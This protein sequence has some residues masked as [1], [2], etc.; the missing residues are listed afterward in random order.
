MFRHPGAAAFD[1]GLMHVA[2]ADLGALE[3][4]VQRS[5]C[6]FQTVIGH[7]GAHH[8]ACQPATGLP[9][10]RQ[11]IQQIVAI[12]RV[13]LVVGHQYTVAVAVEGDA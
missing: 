9:R 7:Q 10:A 4:D 13:A 2:V 8:G 12:D 6:L 11:H 5:Q 1:Q 3:R